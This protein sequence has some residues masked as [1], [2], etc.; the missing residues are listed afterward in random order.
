M[1]PQDAK[2]LVENPPDHL[3]NFNFKVGTGMDQVGYMEGGIDTGMRDM[4]ELVIAQGIMRQMD[5][6]AQQISVEGGGYN[7][8][9]F[10]RRQAAAQQYYGQGPNPGMYTQEGIL[11]PDEGGPTLDQRAN[12]ARLNLPSY[13]NQTGGPMDVPVLGD[14]PVVSKWLLNNAA[15]FGEERSMK[16]YS[17]DY[18]RNKDEND[19]LLRDMESLEDRLDARRRG[20]GG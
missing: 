16:E 9:W 13:M 5:A 10:P 3:R 4:Q 20:G 11:N 17:L 7:Q 6:A 1:T 15:G 19:S 12:Q 18:W 14:I 2:E 8:G